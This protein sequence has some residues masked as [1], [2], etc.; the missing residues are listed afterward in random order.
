MTMKRRKNIK[1]IPFHKAWMDE[2][3]ERALIAT[4]R[5][6][7]LTKGPRTESF[8]EKCA[9]FVGTKYAIGLNSCTAGLHLSLLAAGIG[10][11]DEVI[12]TP[13]TFAATANTIVHTGARPI[14]ADVMYNCGTI[15]PEEICAKTTSRTKAVVAVHLAGH[16]C[17]MTDIVAWCRKK[18]LFLI[19]DA[20]HALGGS[21]K[22][23]NLGAWGNAAAFSFYATKNITTGE[24]GMVTTNDKK[25][26]QRIQIL[27]LH[28]LSKEAWK[29][30]RPGE[31]IFYDVVAPGFKYNMF[32]L[33]AALG[34]VQLEKF[35][36]FTAYRKRVWAHYN[37][38]LRDIPG[39]ELP[40]LPSEGTHA[41][42]LYMI[43]VGGKKLSLTRKE[44]IQKM[45][46]HGI[47]CQVHFI[48]LHL[49][50]YYRKEFK[51]KPYDFPVACKLS[52]SMISLPFYPQLSRHE[53]DYIAEVLKDIMMRAYKR[54]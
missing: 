50:P 10:P 40:T 36:K 42:H 26:A 29:R 27:S 52:E 22:G 30:Y 20:A 21:Y 1:T 16:P 6:G 32:D 23:K 15:S 51:Y 14:F 24:G 5:S 3:E 38:T 13:L 54:Q 8:E 7:W 28:G 46:E 11:G 31:T 19:E 39:I 48:A 45:K 41:E 49:H 4:L 37:K 34:I 43:K 2:K 17:S 9:A 12:T 47:Y 18:N 44:I 35:K 53:V 33:Q 25:I